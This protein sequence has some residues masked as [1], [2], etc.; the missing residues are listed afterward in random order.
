MTTWTLERMTA[1][2]KRAGVDLETGERIGSTAH[3]AHIIEEDKRN[4]WPSITAE[5][6]GRRNG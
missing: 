4:N 5:M 1:F 3:I 2:L 6:E